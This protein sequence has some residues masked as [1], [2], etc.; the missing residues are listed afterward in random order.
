MDMKNYILYIYILFFTLT[1]T[2]VL[3]SDEPVNL[4]DSSIHRMSEQSISSTTFYTAHGAMRGD[5]NIEQ[6][7]KQNTLVIGNGGAGYVGLIKYLA[8]TYNAD[9]SEDSQLTIGWKFADSHM[10]FKSIM[11]GKEGGEACDL[12]I[13]YEPLKERELEELSLVKE[14]VRLF[15]DE[16]PIVGPCSNPANLSPHADP[17]D[18][19]GKIIVYALGLDNRDQKVYYSRW[20]HSAMGVK[21]QQLWCKAVDRLAKKIISLENSDWVIPH[22]NDELQSKITN[23]LENETV[24]YKELKK[25]IGNIIL[26]EF[27]DHHVYKPTKRVFPS[28]AISAT[29]EEGLY[30]ITDG[31]LIVQH[32]IKNYKGVNAQ[33]MKACNIYNHADKGSV[34]HVLTNPAQL[35]IPNSFDE[36]PEHSPQ[37]QFLQWLKSEKGHQAISEFNVRGANAKVKQPYNGMVKQVSLMFAIETNKSTNTYIARVGIVD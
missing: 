32:N 6:L 36:F 7:R 11:K 14:I 23:A 17:I 27:T 3:S 10:N 15:N 20:N 21:D 2:A 22:A 34:D 25:C 30:G 5:Q 4:F 37:Y 24:P 31:A 13:T 26:K 33:D 12:Y 35:L 19:I 9:Q 16:F 8:E 28:G 1:G 18:N 29:M